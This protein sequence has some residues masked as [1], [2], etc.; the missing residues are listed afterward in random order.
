VATLSL[1]VPDELVTR[2]TA[3]LRG[4]YPQHA[5]LTD[6]QLAREVLRLHVRGLVAQWEREQARRKALAAEEAA[7]TKAW[8]ETI[9]IT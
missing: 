3:A 1:T 9:T 5:A 4:L 7:H 8:D 2:V 6:A